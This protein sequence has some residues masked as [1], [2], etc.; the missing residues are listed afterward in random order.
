MATRFTM[1]FVSHGNL[2]RHFGRHGVEMGFKSAEAYGRAG[3]A[4]IRTAGK[5]GV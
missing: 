1:G 4:F 5:E 3:L 2:M